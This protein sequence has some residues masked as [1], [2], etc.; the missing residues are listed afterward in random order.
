MSD[1][2]LVLGYSNYVTTI[3]YFHFYSDYKSSNLM[4]S[5]PDDIVDTLTTVNMT[6][7]YHHW[8]LSPTVS[9]TYINPN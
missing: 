2:L 8:G 9:K 4:S 6:F 5:M 7:N 1:I 3:V